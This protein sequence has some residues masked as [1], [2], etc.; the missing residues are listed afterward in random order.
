MTPRQYCNT[1]GPSQTFDD[2]P[3]CRICLKIMAERGKIR[4]K[5]FQLASSAFC[6]DML[7]MMPDT[8]Q[9]LGI[10]HIVPSLGQIQPGFRFKEAGNTYL[11]CNMLQGRSASRSAEDTAPAFDGLLPF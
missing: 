4:A 9:G 11:H 7:V 1:C 5:G 8:S 2:A 6:K 3:S 10:Q